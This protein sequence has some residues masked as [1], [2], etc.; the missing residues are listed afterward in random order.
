MFNVQKYIKILMKKILLILIVF[1]VLLRF[2]IF[3]QND[4][5]ISNFMFSKLWYNPAFAGSNK[6]TINALIL[7]RQQWV[8]FETAPATQIFELDTYFKKFGG[9]GLS[10]INDKLGYEKSISPKIMYSYQ[11]QVSE[12]SF[13]SAGIG[14]GAINKSLDGTKYIYENKD[15][16]DPNGIYDI[17]NEIEPELDFGLT[18]T[19]QKFTLGLSSTHITKS[20]KNASFIKIPRHYYF[21]ADYNIKMNNKVNIIPSFYI[22]SNKVITHYEINTNVIFAK[23]FRAGLSYRLSESVIGLLGMNITPNIK[24]GYSYD[25]DV[26]VIEKYSSGSHEIFLICSFNKPYKPYI[27]YKTPR[28]FN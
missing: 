21:Y 25:F 4:V 18:F 19:N 6:T 16:T 24:I 23:K 1:S 2:D 3:S 8:G 11:K 15:I 7:A 12:K 5:Q 17:E 20:N 28:L 13:I 10:I 9:I 22:K 14:L 26:G 27:Y